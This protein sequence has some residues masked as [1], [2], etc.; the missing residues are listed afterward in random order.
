VKGGVDAGAN[1][2]GNRVYMHTKRHEVILRDSA[3]ERVS[4][5]GAI[6][7]IDAETSTGLHSIPTMRPP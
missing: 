3:L 1:G 6:V 2:Y 4:E 7:D 5:M